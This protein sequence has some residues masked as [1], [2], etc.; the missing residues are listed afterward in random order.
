M[1]RSPYFINQPCYLMCPPFTTRNETINNPWMAKFHEGYNYPKAFEQFLNLYKELSKSGFVYLLTH[2]GNFQDI[3]FVSNSALILAHTPNVA[4]MANFTSLPRLGEEIVAKKFLTSLGYETVSVPN[5]W[6]GNADLKHLRDNIYI[7]GVGIRSTIDAFNWMSIH[8]NMRV[9]DVEI[10]DPYL[11]HLDCSIM[12]LNSSTLLVVTSN[13]TA[14]DLQ[15]LENIATVIDVPAKWAR[16][17][18]TNGIK[19]GNTII[20]DD[21]RGNQRK[22]YVGLLEWL[23]F[24]VKFIDTSEFLK[25]GASPSCMVLPLNYA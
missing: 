13:F 9:I 16:E 8:Y 21:L 19:I 3:T 10:K 11:Y 15:K 12:P 25:S 24:E 5:K 14:K 18:W 7:G 1:Y 22:D 2:E 4:L 23:G 20:Q 6:E 17:G